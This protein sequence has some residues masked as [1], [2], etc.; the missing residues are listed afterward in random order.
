MAT[1]AQIAANCLNAQKSTGPRTA[2]GK[3]A[4]ARNA[5]KHG[6][7]AR[8]AVIRGEDPEDFETHRQAVVADL[9]PV[10]AVESALAERV[11]GLIWRLRR[12][13]RLQNEA[14]EVMYRKEAIC[15]YGRGRRGDMARTP[16]GPQGELGPDDL[17]VGRVIGRDFAGYRT[18][19]H[20]GLYERRLEHSLYRTTAELK[21]LQRLRKAEAAPPEAESHSDGDDADEP[22]VE[23]TQVEQWSPE[24]MVKA[25]RCWEDTQAETQRRRND[26]KI[27][28]G[29]LDG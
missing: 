20:L 10:G 21:R 22:Q 5:I 24:P 6:L 26:E 4:V 7:L 12:A 9:A 16:A 3:A 2:E 1:Q 13:E 28:V 18:L 14:L 25:A 29:C 19:E 15:N 17:I 27:T 23:E 8:D 11:A